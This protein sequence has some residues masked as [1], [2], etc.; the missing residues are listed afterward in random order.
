MSATRPAVG[1]PR[2][3]DVEK[4]LDR[5]MHVFWHQGYDGASLANLTRAMG[6]SRPSLYSAFG[7]KQ[8]LF[9]KALDRYDAVPSAY[10]RE[11]LAEP[12]ARAFVERLLRGAA[13]MQTDPATPPGC[14]M[15]QGAL[16]GGDG[17]AAVRQEV[18][19]RRAAGEAMVRRRLRRARTEGELPKDTD[20]DG[21]ALYVVT[22]IRGMAV[23]ASGGATRADLEG[24][25]R[26]ALRAWP[27]RPRKRRRAR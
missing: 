10:V 16:V 9:L 15:V 2:A 23:Q 3:F 11:A 19:E 18:N 4:A 6:I 14:L 27:P 1:R 17:A 24:V 20:P 25:I 8:S 5:A 13:D 12:T 7:D 21:L 22:V 26:T